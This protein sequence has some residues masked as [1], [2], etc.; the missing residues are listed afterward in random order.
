MW[1][2]RENKAQADVFTCKCS[3]AA[4]RDLQ[5]EKCNICKKT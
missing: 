4:D 3:E 1:K 5:G 2:R